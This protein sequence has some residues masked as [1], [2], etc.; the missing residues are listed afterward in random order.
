VK[1]AKKY[2]DEDILEQ[3]KGDVDSFILFLCEN[4]MIEEA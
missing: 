4:S 3:I 2:G 1:L